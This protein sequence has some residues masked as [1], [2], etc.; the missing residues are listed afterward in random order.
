MTPT[1]LRVNF[2][3]EV[4]RPCSDSGWRGRGQIR[5][6]EEFNIPLFIVIRCI[7]KHLMQHQPW[8]VD[9][10]QTAASR[11]NSYLL[12]IFFHKVSSGPVVTDPCAAP[13]TFACRIQ[14][15]RWYA[16]FLPHCQQVL[17]HVGAQEASIAVTFHQLVDVV[18]NRS[19]EKMQ[20]FA[21]AHRQGDVSCLHI[22]AD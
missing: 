2:S 5:I 3:R 4:R 15:A 13:T 22:S 18:L 9:F 8:C 7:Y 12:H 14:S 6:G 11:L 21:G 16:Y 10:S 1:T 19:R 17:V 20:L